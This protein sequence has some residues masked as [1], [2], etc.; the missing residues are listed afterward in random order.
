MKS[1]WEARDATSYCPCLNESIQSF[2]GGAKG[3]VSSLEE[4][5]FF[6]FLIRANDCLPRETKISK[7]EEAKSS[8]GVVHLN[9][10][11]NSL[12]VIV[13]SKEDHIPGHAFERTAHQ[14]SQ[15]GHRNIGAEVRSVALYLVS[16]MSRA[17]ADSVRTED[18][19]I[20]RGWL[21]RPGNFAVQRCTDDR[22]HVSDISADKRL[23]YLVFS[24]DVM[25]ER[26]VAKELEGHK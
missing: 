9:V 7:E 15:V 24:S 26:I 13:S 1:W 11:V 12:I 10:C 3:F 6:P 20:A 2:D 25:I 19:F 14:R 5:A 18:I 16:P 17:V 22:D 8:E 23:R 4:T 21:Q